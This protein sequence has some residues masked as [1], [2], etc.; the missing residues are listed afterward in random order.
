MTNKIRIT[1]QD[2]INHWNVIRIQTKEET[3]AEVE[4]LIVEELVKTGNTRMDGQ[5]GNREVEIKL[6]NKFRL[7]LKEMKT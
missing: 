6:L 1:E 7:K 2:L 4:K 5:F 3:L